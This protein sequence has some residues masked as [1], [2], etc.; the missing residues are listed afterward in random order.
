LRSTFNLCRYNE[1]FAGA[2]V[3]G[4]EKGW[5]SVFTFQAVFGGAVHVE[6]C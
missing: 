1:L 4:L 3:S 5:K 6:L 2:G